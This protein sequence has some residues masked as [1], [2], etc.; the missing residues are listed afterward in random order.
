MF[1]AFPP[2]ARQLLPRDQ[3]E[4]AAKRAVNASQLG[5][6]VSANKDADSSILQGLVEGSDA[7]LC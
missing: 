2:S 4:A 6:V 3:I 1:A 5:V 7:F